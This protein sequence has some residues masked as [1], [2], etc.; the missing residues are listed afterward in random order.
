MDDELPR[1]YYSFD[2][3]K[4][5]PFDTEEPPVYVF[6]TIR[7]NPSISLQ[8]F[9]CSQIHLMTNVFGFFVAGSMQ[10]LILLEKE[11]YNVDHDTAGR[12]TSLTLVLQLLLKMCVSVS[13]GHLCDK[14]G[15]RAMI[16]YGACSYLLSCIVVSTQ[17]TIF[18][19]FIA[20][21]LLL[22]NAGSAIGSVP[23]LADYI[24]DDSKGKGIGI[25][26]FIFSFSALFG[27]LF[28]KALFYHELSLRTCYIVTGTVVFCI[29]IINSFGLKD[30][31]YYLFNQGKHPTEYVNIPIRERV[32]DAIQ[33][34]KSNGWLIIALLVQIIGS[35]D[36]YIF[37]TFL[38]LY[39][40]SM[41]T[42]VISDANFNILVNNL[43]TMVIVPSIL[44]NF[45]YGYMLDKK[46]KP[47]E[48]VLFG[49]SGGTVA[50]FLICFI[51]GPD[52]FKISISALL[53]GLTIPG[54]FVV[55]MY[56]S[57]KH[58]PAD[59]RGI[60]IG[61][62]SLVGHI[63]YFVIAVGGGFLY[64]YWRKDGPFILCTIL[65]IVTLGLVLL[66]H[67]KMIAN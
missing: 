6:K 58:F 19:G 9:I 35:S 48:T 5:Q 52:D 62:K 63:G 38:I 21:K 67:K 65:F 54:L 41:A 45:L 15:R 39:V 27:N 4:I 57:I 7:L 30:G 44:C 17:T 22:A 29:F 25:S 3:E 33:V 49:L 42:E 20:G 12:I 66:V 46:N 28:L 56:L 31:K 53:M 23:L 1:P 32:T 10:P 2:N 16:Y 14:F 51:T 24:H 61:F 47:L 36:F 37:F 11:Y 34:F 64:D 8:N 50:S 43:Q 40:K 59:K 18:P 55:S 60:M 13:Y 26:A